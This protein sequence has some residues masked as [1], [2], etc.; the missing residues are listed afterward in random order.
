MSRK[1]LD[2]KNEYNKNRPREKM[3]S[4]KTRNDVIKKTK[5]ALSRNFSKR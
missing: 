4:H 2:S 5:K 1:S 3:K